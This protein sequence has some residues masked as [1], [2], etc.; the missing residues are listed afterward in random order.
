M[1]GR[2]TRRQFVKGLAVATGSTVLAA[3]APKTVK[4][5]VVVEKSVKETVV[6]TEE[7]VVTATPAPAE[8]AVVTIMHD[9]K[10][11][12]EDQEAQFE[13]DHPEIQIE[14]VDQDVTRFVADYAA[15]RPAD[16]LRVQAPSIPQ[17]LARGML[18]NLTPYF[19]AS[20]LVPLDDLAPANDYYKAL[21]PFNIGSGL[22]YGMCKDWSPDFTVYLYKTAF[23]EAGVD[24]PD[25]TEPPTY[26]ELLELARKVSKKEGD[27]TLTFGFDYELGWIGRMI[28][29]IL[30][31]TG[32]TLYVDSGIT[33]SQ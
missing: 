18:F 12:T 22:I 29:N 33:A 19:E 2:L 1:S 17:F 8:A 4:E 27:R 23:E 5:T 32:Q 30:A 28:G 3:C 7:K 9:R 26:A 24:V 21:G 14:F 6:V 20:D 25:H 13:A 31:E 10:E 16:L 11:L 15:G